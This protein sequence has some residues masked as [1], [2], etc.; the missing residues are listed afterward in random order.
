MFD[1]VVNFV[2]VLVAVLAACS[3]VI[4]VGRALYR[5]LGPSWYNTPTFWQVPLTSYKVRGFL[6]PPILRLFFSSHMAI[7]SRR[8]W[9][10][11]GLN[12]HH[13]GCNG[14]GRDL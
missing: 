2:V 11:N 6:A 1:L 5:M 13:R 8:E 3:V 14:R 4:D 9:T 12:S 10:T 7:P